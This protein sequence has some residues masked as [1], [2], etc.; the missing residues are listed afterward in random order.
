MNAHTVKRFARRLLAVTTFHGFTCG[1]LPKQ[2]LVFVAAPADPRFQY[3]DEVPIGECRQA[4]PPGNLASCH[5]ARRGDQGAYDGGAHGQVPP[6]A[7][8]AGDEILIACTYQ[9]QSPAGRRPPIVRPVLAPAID[10]VKGKTTMTDWL[11]GAAEAEA[12]SVGAFAILA[13]ELTALGAERK[14]VRAARA[15]MKDEIVHARMMRRLARI[16][17]P[18][19]T[20]TRKQPVVPSRSLVAFAE[21]NAAEGCVRE[22]FGV[23]L[24]AFQAAH[25]SDPRVRVAMTRIVADEARH[26]A[27]AF[28][29]DAWARERL[30]KTAQKRVRSAERAAIAE[31]R[32]AVRT[33]PDGDAQLG[34]PTREDA[35]RMLGTL[36]SALRKQRARLATV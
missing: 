1:P 34:L 12:E 4:C 23:A 22:T 27:L 35:S 7:K 13:A 26:A 28:R 33:W 17:T 14:Y 31:L 19:K 24:A 9:I 29:I 8:D 11:H 10:D 3:G 15:A 20:D 36:S 30:S 18:K 16:K 6:I 21:H 5:Y 25:A 32:S 2:T